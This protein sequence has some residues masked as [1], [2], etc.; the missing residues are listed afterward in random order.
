MDSDTGSP[1]VCTQCLTEGGK[2]E[3]GGERGV[4]PGQR[5]MS[6]RKTAEG[7]GKRWEERMMGRKARRPMRAKRLPVGARIRMAPT[8]TGPEN[9]RLKAASEDLEMAPRPH[10]Y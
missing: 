10:C 4:G 1:S 6:Q 7:C 2:W 5:H 8:G 3:G 9:S